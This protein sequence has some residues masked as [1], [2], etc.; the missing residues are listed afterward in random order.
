M[1][2][3]DPLDGG[4]V[5]LDRGEATAVADRSVQRGARCE[6][7][8]GQEVRHAAAGVDDRSGTTKSRRA[9]SNRGGRSCPAPLRGC[10]AA[11]RRARWTTSP[12]RRRSRDG[13]ARWSSPAPAAA[14]RSRRR[15][16]RRPRR[17]APCTRG[18]RCRR[19]GRPRTTSATAADVGRA[20]PSAARS[21]AAR[22]AAGS[23]ATRHRRPARGARC[24]SRRPRPRPVGR[25]RGAR[26]RSADASSGNGG[27]GRRSR[28]GW[29]RCGDGHRRRSAVL[30]RARSGRRRASAWWSTRGRGSWCP[31]PT[32]AGGRPPSPRAPAE[33]RRGPRRSRAG[34]PPRGPPRSSRPGRRSAPWD[35]GRPWCPR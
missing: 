3:A 10:R 22:A 8:V 6:L 4:D 9:R 5:E 17:G 19:P 12:R 16:R 31:A 33:R 35:Q 7:C 15:T 11:W 21:T 1:L 23:P 24:R 34:C 20:P 30:R 26:A 32:A 13:G 25:H 18:P 29:R 2:V 14:R 28:R 27:G